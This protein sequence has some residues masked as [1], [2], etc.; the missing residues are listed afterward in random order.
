MRRAQR[1]LSL[2][3]CA[4]SARLGP[5]EGPA[6]GHPAVSVLP[7]PSSFTWNAGT[8]DGETVSPILQVK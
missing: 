7:V 2:S 1:A 3:L 8:L 6:E 5:H 4:V